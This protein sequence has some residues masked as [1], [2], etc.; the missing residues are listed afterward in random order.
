METGKNTCAFSRGISAEPLE[1]IVS[2][3]MSQD[4]QEVQIGTTGADGIIYIKFPDGKI[5][6]YKEIE[7][8]RPE[9]NETYMGEFKVEDTECN[10]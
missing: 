10:G 3:K 7:F 1:N 5:K 6:F 4:K 2:H 8:K 9:W